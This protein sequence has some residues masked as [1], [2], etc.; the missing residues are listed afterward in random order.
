M[1]APPRRIRTKVVRVTTRRTLNWN[2]ESVG[3]AT[4]RVVKIFCTFLFSVF[5]S[6][7]TGTAGLGTLTKSCFD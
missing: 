1:H 3:F 5:F 6:V 2:K 4:F 7:V